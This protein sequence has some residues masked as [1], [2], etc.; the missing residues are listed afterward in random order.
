MSDNWLWLVSGTVI[1][2]LVGAIL[3]GLS[4]A[5]RT[6]R[7]S[8]KIETGHEALQ[9]T[10]TTDL[11]AVRSDI[12]RLLETIANPIEPDLVVPEDPL[13]EASLD[14]FL[15][16]LLSARV[17]RAN[18]DT[19]EGIRSR[20]SRLDEDLKTGS[21]TEARR[22]FQGLTD[23]LEEYLGSKLLDSES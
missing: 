9:R 14:H 19:A 8:N 10:D 13:N 20:M 18:R 1:G 22:S 23:L 6:A 2:G 5:H 11:G 3:K 15:V 12:A 17:G 4:G 21:I 16:Q 7:N